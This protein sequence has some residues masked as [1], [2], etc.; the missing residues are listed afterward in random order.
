MTLGTITFPNS[1]G[2]LGQSLTTD[3][4]GNITWQSGGNSATGLVPYTGATSS[5]NLGAYDL[6]VNGLTIGRGANG[7]IENNTALGINALLSSVNSGE[8]NTAVGYNSMPYYIGNGRDYN[9]SV[10]YNNMLGLTTGYAN[11]SIGGE[12]MFHLGNGIGNT[13]IGSHTLLS[14]TGSGNTAVGSESGNGV[15]GGSNNTFLG[16]GSDVSDGSIS[17]ATAIGKNAIVNSSNTIQLGGTSLLSVNTSGYYTGSAFT[18]SSDKRLKTNIVPVVNGIKT[19]MLLNPVHYEK[20]SSLDSNANLVVENG[21]IAQE[22][23]K[24][25]PF[26]VKEGF[27]KNKLLSLD[28]TSIIP[29]LTRAIQEQQLELENQKKIFVEQNKKIKKIEDKLDIFLKNNNK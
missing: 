23:K 25:I 6:K 12:T 2:L 3:G 18:T 9:T 19:V 27:D 7:A 26:I 17:N 10:G 20:K 14:T 16:L 28:Y 21:F 8:R 29:I 24:I 1:D 15:V 13:A 22:I 5:V 4:N 11:T